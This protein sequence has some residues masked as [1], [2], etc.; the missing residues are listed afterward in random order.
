MSYTHTQR[1]PLHYL[2][3]LPVAILAIVA[4]QEDLDFFERIG[5]GA[6]AGVLLLLE[7]SFQTLTVEDLGNRLRVRFGMLPVF[8]KS[9]TY[10]SITKVKP[11]RSWLIDGWGIHYVP[12]R[13]WTWNLW[14]LDCVEITDSK[15]RVLRV[16]T[17]DPQGLAEFLNSKL[18]A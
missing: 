18:S 3:L 15:G 14:G 1:A 16:G 2:L 9:I 7:F 17:D 5:I 13:G 10:G 8:Q 6:V 4:S 12:G 11:A